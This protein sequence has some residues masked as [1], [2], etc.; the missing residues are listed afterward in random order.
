M[1]ELLELRTC[2][3]QQR[4][5][6]ALTLI[7][8]MEEMSKEDKI[9]KIE[10][11]AEVLLLHLIKQAAEKRITRSWNLSIANAIRHIRRTNKRRKSG[12][13]YLEADELREIV[14]EAWQPA[15]ERAALEA[16]EGRHDAGELRQMVDQEAIEQ[17]AFDLI[18]AEDHTAFSN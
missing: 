2:I 12:G 15:L 6:D 14:R 1:E 11:F 3:E 10:S 16:F 7:A 18:T 8:E 4:Y 5:A 17:K 13:H 9:N